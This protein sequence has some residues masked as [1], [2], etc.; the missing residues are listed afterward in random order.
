VG[1]VEVNGYEIGP[2]ADLKGATLRKADFTGAH[3]YWVN[4]TGADLTGAGLLGADLSGV[5]LERVK[6]DEDTIWPAG[7][8]PV[9]AGV[10]FD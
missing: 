3:L 9:A 6:A 5:S 10:I 4:L 1:V 2:G 8:D 7:F